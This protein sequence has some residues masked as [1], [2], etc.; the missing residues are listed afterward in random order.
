MVLPDTTLVP[1]AAYQ[2][3]IEVPGQSKEKIFEKSKQWLALNFSSSKKVIEYENAS[4]GKLIGKGTL[5]LSFTI[6]DTLIGPQTT[7]YGVGYT[8]TQDIKD[9]KTR[10]SFDN[11]ALLNLYGVGYSAIYKDGWRQLEPQLVSLAE[12]L[13]NYLIST[14]DTKW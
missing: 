4:E 7:M 1:D 10:I 3:I 14:P 5:S 13:K 9:N 8:I 2:E 11:I 6:E 12:N